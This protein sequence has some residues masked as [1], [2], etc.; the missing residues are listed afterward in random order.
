MTDKERLESVIKHSKM[1]VN[2]FAMSLGLTRSTK[3]YNIINQKNGISPAMANLITSVYS[4]INFDWLLTGE[5][6]M[7]KV[8]PT[9][10]PAKEADQPSQLYEI[11]L[12]QQETIAKLTDRLLELTDDL[13]P[14]KDQ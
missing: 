4:E 5:G 2:A 12:K 11:I 14:K 13:K 1:S 7:L 9:P 3:I 6:E 10:D 8:D